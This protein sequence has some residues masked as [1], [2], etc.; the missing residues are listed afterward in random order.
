MNRRSLDK[1]I[2][3]SAYF[4]IA[5]P[6]LIFI[7]GWI[8]WTI[9]IPAALALC[10]C[11]FLAITAEKSRPAEEVSFEVTKKTLYVS[12]GFVVVWLFM[13]GIAGFTYQ[14]E[15]HQYRNA[16]FSDLTTRSWPT[17][18]SIGGNGAVAALNNKETILAYYIG[19][20]LPSA[21]IGKVLGI[22]AGKFFLYLWSLAGV[23]FILYFTF[24]YLRRFSFPLLLIVLFF[25]HA[26]IIGS[27]KYYSI[28]DLI[29]FDYRLWS[30]RLAIA[31]SI[32]SGVY[33][34]Y[35][36]YIIPVLVFTLILNKIAPKNLVFIYVFVFFQGPFAFL[37][38]APFILFD[39]IKQ[40]RSDNKGIVE[41]ITRYI[42]IQNIF[43][44]VV[45]LP[46]FYL[47]L[48][49]NTAAQHSTILH[50]KPQTALLFLATTFG[51][52]SVLI[53]PKYKREP[54]YYFTIALLTIIPFIQ[55]GHGSDFGNRVSVPAMFM[56]MLMVT[57]FIIDNGYGKLKPFVIL[58]VCIACSSSVLSLF[59]SVSF[60]VWNITDHKAASEYI[61]DRSNEYHYQKTIGKK[62]GEDPAKNYLIQNDLKTLDNPA[63][64]AM[65]NFMAEKEKSV[66][67]KYL[68]KRE[69]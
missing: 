9:A 49:G 57:R 36:Q 52:I 13:S 1:Y 33:W 44:A 15:D 8:K 50:V 24:K 19:Y 21:A 60:T 22:G 53:F 25:G 18:Y 31:D 58:Y 12:I 51:L 64:M 28:S 32:H 45:M 47:Y 6:A 23:L 16:I 14:N 30:A 61:Y 66:F 11:F 40:Y 7:L 34:V 65:G 39:M 46:M 43:G 37:G 67:Y 62:P 4:Y 59:R 10:Y 41:F 56:L 38:I 69:K 5:I 26:Y 68:A 54:I 35:N 27:L 63:N 48:S 2:T 3:Y 29:K 55:V 20:W 42:S 17:V